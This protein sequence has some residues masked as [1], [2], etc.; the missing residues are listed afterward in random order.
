MASRDVVHEIVTVLDIAAVD[1]NEYVAGLDASR[2]STTVRSDDAND[3]TVRKSIDATDCRRLCGLELDADRASNDLMFRTDE[4]VV[5][6]RDNVGR[7]G[8]ADTLRTHVLGINGGVHADDLAGHVDERTAG[9]AGVNGGIG[10]D[11]ALELRLG[12]PVG[13]SLLDTAVLRG[14]NAC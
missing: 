13:A 7:H 3:H 8:K 6:I 11:K 14:D 12:D 9:V 1:R 2:G 5:H 4:H 10:L